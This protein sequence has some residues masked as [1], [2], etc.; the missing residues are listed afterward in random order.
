MKTLIFL[1]AAFFSI[2]LMSCTDTVV[3]PNALGAGYSKYDAYQL[4]RLDGARDAK[5]PRAGYL[6]RVNDKSRVPAFYREE[7]LRGYANGFNDPHSVHMV[8]SK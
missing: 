5:S 8:G 1:A 3:V 4:G 2:T 7:Y 6:P